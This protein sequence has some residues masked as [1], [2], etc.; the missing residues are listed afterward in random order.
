MPY[1]YPIVTKFYQN[2]FYTPALKLDFQT[3]AKARKQIRQAE[4]C[5]IQKKN[6]KSNRSCQEQTRLQF[7]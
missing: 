7:E 3:S 2:N 5:A 6:C 4:V 1:P